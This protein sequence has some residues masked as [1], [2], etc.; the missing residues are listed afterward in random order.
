MSSLSNIMEAPSKPVTAKDCK[1]EWKECI[2]QPPYDMRACSNKRRECLR[3]RSKANRESNALA[4]QLS[5]ME[6]KRQLPGEKPFVM[7]SKAMEITTS[8]VKAAD[9]SKQVFKDSHGTSFKLP[10]AVLDRTKCKGKNGSEKCGV[11]IQVKMWDPKVHGMEVIG[12]DGD[13]VSNATADGNQTDLSGELSKLASGITSLTVCENDDE[14][15]EVAVHDLDKGDK[16]S[17]ITFDMKIEPLSDA[18]QKAVDSGEYEYKPQCAWFDPA[19]QQ[20]KKD[21]CHLVMWNNETN[22]V[23][24]RCSHLT[25]FALFAQ[26]QRIQANVAKCEKDHPGYKSWDTNTLID[27]LVEKT[28]CRDNT[29]KTKEVTCTEEDKEEFRKQYTQTAE[30]QDGRQK[31]EEK[32]C[33]GTVS[34]ETIKAALTV[35]LYVGIANY[36]LTFVVLI[37]LLRFTVPT[38]ARAKNFSDLTLK[39]TVAD[40]QCMIVLVSTLMRGTNALLKWKAREDVANGGNLNA[41][42][43][44]ASMLFMFWGASLTVANWMTIIHHTV[45]KGSKSPISGLGPYYLGFNITIIVL[46]AIAWIGLYNR[47]AVAGG[48]NNGWAV[49]GQ[50]C[51]AIPELMLSVSAVVYGTLLIK[52][53][54]NSMQKFSGSEET[55][56]RQLVAC[57]KTALIFVVFSGTFFLQSVLDIIA[58]VAPDLYYTEIRHNGIIPVAPMDLSHATCSVMVNLI[59]IFVVVKYEEVTQIAHEVVLPVTL[60]YTQASKLLSTGYARVPEADDLDGS[61]VP[62]GRGPKSG[63]L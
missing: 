58:G 53:I 48:G 38:L 42:M 63:S 29:D 2:F 35:Q 18:A 6:M 20:L 15:T 23:T 45:K 33:G 55:K 30:Q 24:C 17:F 10:S 21:G 31:L 41:Q 47:T 44:M 56:Q 25:D 60:L 34:F 43:I 57:R 61:R 36:I 12:I 26:V 11:N 3:N 59:I 40:Y 39:L 19:D 54:R 14:S 37:K 4:K 49:M 8:K 5:A 52:M 27:K 62:A 46:L 7:K 13:K 1:E 9:L 50:M 22:M 28:E 16:P 51:L 32:L